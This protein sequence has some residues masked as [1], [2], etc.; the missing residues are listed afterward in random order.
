M[1]WYDSNHDYVNDYIERWNK[2]AGRA[3]AGM[4]VLGII[5]ALAGVAAIAAPIGTYL[6]IQTAI[7]VVLIVHGIGQVAAYI[8]TPEFFR[9]GAQ[10]ATGILNAVL[11]VLL[12]AILVLLVVL[13]FRGCTPSTLVDDNAVMTIGSDDSSSSRT[14]TLSPSDSDSDSDEVEDGGTAADDE[15]STVDQNDPD[16]ADSEEKPQ[17]TKVKISVADGDSSWV[18]IRLDGSV[19]FGNEVYGPWEQEYTVT[20][21]IRITANEPGSVSVTMNG[22]DVRWDTSTSGVARINITAPEPEP[23]SDDSAEGA[24]GSDTGADNQDQAAA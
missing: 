13:L 8:Q 22:E 19:V 17:E 20:D 6:F 18:E 10:L 7:A 9:N 2:T 11:G 21:S 23:A 3:K 24:E 15:S 12:L 4:I 14:D 5:L 1:N 16:A